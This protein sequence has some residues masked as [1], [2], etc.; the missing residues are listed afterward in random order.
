MSSDLISS[1][2]PIIDQTELP[3]RP[4]GPVPPSEGDASAPNLSAEPPAPLQTKDSGTLF[5]D[6]PEEHKPVL[7]KLALLVQ[8]NLS[9]GDT[10]AARK[11]LNKMDVRM[12]ALDDNQ[13]TR[14]RAWCEEQRKDV[15]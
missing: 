1:T 4:I 10:K 2:Y 9:R 15:K 7:Q 14:L 6:I 5:S 11:K 3:T 12:Q 13:G 8:T